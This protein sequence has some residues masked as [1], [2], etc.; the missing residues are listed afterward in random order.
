[1]LSITFHNCK[2]LI[3]SQKPVQKGLNQVVDTMLPSKQIV[4]VSLSES[5]HVEDTESSSVRIDGIHNIIKVSHD[6]GRFL[7]FED[8]RSIGKDYVLV[9]ME[10]E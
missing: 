2:G 3:P 6:C 9:L 5:H 4:V 8:I 1:M 7:E 10:D